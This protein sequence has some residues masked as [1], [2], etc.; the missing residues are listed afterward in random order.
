MKDDIP[1]GAR[2]WIGWTL[3][4]IVLLLILFGWL[5]IRGMGAGDALTQAGRT[6]VSLQ[7]AIASDDARKIELFSERLAE[8]TGSAHSLTSDPVW[9]VAEF[10][11]GVGSG[12]R[13]L[14][15]VAAAS[16]EL[17]T[18]A[19][20]HLVTASQGFSLGTF[21]LTGNVIDLSG[22]DAARL[23]LQRAAAAAEKVG[24]TLQEIDPASAG[25]PL[26]ASARDAHAA[27]THAAG[28][29]EALGATIDLLP[30]I[31]G[32]HEPHT[33]L[34]I[35][36][37]DTRLPGSDAIDSISRLTADAGTITYEGTTTARG[38]PALAEPLPAGAEFAAHGAFIADSW[39]EQH[40]A[41]VNV[42]IMVDAH[43]LAHVLDAV[44]EV[45]TSDATFAARTVVT[46]LTEELAAEIESPEEQ[47]AYFARAAGAILLAALE[48]RDPG[49]LVAG[50]ADAADAGHIVLWS[51][52]E[53]E[54]S[55]LAASALGHYP[56]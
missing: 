49:A 31:A 19:L 38:I 37:N 15:E 50:L 18:E 7:E 53:D 8:Q 52:Q 39:Q 10:V 17:A 44:G 2:P 28:R 12:M 42:V 4:G 29:I 26:Q 9:R 30:P 14:R 46:A 11:P 16:E 21:G 56:R 41:P 1:T 33:I 55:R 24:Q 6:A 22:H 25:G 32:L 40:G 45:H 35:G 20:P 54:Q 23:H 34:I 43:A 13:V 27:L 36:V 5:V 48:A 47:N 51:A 3:A